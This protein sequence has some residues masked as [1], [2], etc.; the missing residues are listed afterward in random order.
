[1]SFSSK[2]KEEL[3]TISRKDFTLKGKTSFFCKYSVDKVRYFYYTKV[4]LAY[5][6]YYKIGGFFN[7]FF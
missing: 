2:V 5:I 3:A 1:M 6:L 4:E 7:R